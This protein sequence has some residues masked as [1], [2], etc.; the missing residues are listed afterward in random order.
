VTGYVPLPRLDSAVG[1]GP[2]LTSG[3]GAFD[4]ALM[5]APN[6]APASDDVTP[7]EVPQRISEAADTM[8]AIRAGEVDA[9]VMSR[10]DDHQV[11]SLTTADTPYRKFVENMRDG[12]AT[13]SSAGVVLY[14][15]RRLAELL[16]RPREAIVGKV[17]AQFLADPPNW[18]DARGEDGLG[19]DIEGELLAAVPVPVLIGMY[20]LDLGDFSVMCLTF[21][22][23]TAQRAQEESIARLNLAQMDRVAELQTAHV[24]LT[25]LA[26]RDALTGL[27]NRALLV[28]RI[29]QSLAQAK[30]SRARVAVFF[31]D[32]D[33]FKRVNDT[34]GHAAGDR[35]LQRVAAQLEAVVRPM[36]TVARIGGDEFAVLAPV[37]DSDIH[38]LEIGHRMISHLSLLSSDGPTTSASI[39]L[40]VALDGNGNAESLLDQ[41]DTAMYQ[42]KSR[43]GGRTH[44][45][46]AALGVQVQQRFAAERAVQLAL[47]DDRVVAYYQPVIDL[48]TGDLAGFEALARIVQLD[49][50][51]LLPGSFIPAAE[52]SGLVVPL[53]SRVLALA[54]D[55]AHRW[56]TTDN[57]PLTIAVNLSPRQFERGNLMAIVEARLRITGLDPRLLLLELTETTILDLLPDIIDQLHQLRDMGV[58]IGLDDFGT[59]YASL[60]HLRN[61]PLT[62]VKI[63]RSFVSGIGVDLE[64][65]R[66]VS[67]VVDLAGNLGLRSIAEGVETLEQVEALR[68]YGCDQV[69]GFLFARP[70][71]ATDLPAALARRGW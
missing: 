43:G 6:R 18:D 22:D 67:A 45:F 33:G 61:M 64:D 58:E 53:G 63:D 66:I 13:V 36:D 71:P 14:A 1:D 60:T 12:A 65:E 9:F 11:L 46:D 42:A 50:S 17:L 41:A 70:L 39:G 15:N 4:E 55:E 29:T 59:G 68:A 28:D 62:F 5:V 34:L 35:I 38:A 19:G 23:L 52:G 69:Q 57:R 48:G 47:D 10:G 20:I 8:R 26:T 27:P 2:K 32:L 44:L 25:A 37:V 30:R 21:T 54:I 31:V 3:V 16:D 51:L 56:A 7:E 40:A 24:A 49:K